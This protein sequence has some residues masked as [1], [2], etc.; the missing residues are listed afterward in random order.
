MG[1]SPD[2]RY[3]VCLMACTLRVRG[4][5]LQERLHGGGERVVRVVQQD[6]ARRMAANTLAGLGVSDSLRYRDVCGTCLG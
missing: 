5:L 4:G 2:V 3:R 1:E 6:V